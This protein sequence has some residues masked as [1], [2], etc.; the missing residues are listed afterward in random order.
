[1]PRVMMLG[2]LPLA[3]A[4]RPTPGRVVGMTRGLHGLGDL[5]ETCND[6]GVAIG[7]ALSSSAGAGFGTATGDSTEAQ[8]ARAFGAAFSGFSANLS[9]A[10]A[11]ARAAAASGDP[12]AAQDLQAA[13]DIERARNEGYQASISMQQQSSGGTVAKDYTPYYVVGG[14]GVLGL[15][16]ALFILK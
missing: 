5:L 13:L 3:G 9:T 1:M 15:L 4:Y 14:L 8:A 7:S 10:C 6:P 11:Q 12:T 2:N 16:A